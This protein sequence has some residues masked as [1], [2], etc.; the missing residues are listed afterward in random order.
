MSDRELTQLISVAKYY[1]DA[2]DSLAVPDHELASTVS[3]DSATWSTDRLPRPLSPL[4]AYSAHLAS[5]ATRLATIHEILAGD[6]K[7]AWAAAYPN[8]ADPTDANVRLAI[9]QALEILLRDNVG[10]AEDPPGFRKA[11]FRKA[12]LAQLSFK[13]IRGCLQTRY[14]TLADKMLRGQHA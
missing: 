10:H 4:D 14:Q 13:K 5:C 7:R 8:N 9:T 11:T 1:L 3:A 12:A 2:A 6:F